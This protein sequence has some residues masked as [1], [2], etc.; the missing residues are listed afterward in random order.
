[1]KQIV[2][3][4]AGKIG[5]TICNIL[6]TCGDYHITVADASQQQLDQADM[7]EST[8]RVQLNVN[9]EKALETNLKGKF[10]VM[11]AAPFHVTSKV[12]EGAKR[13]KI[14]YLDLTEDVA[15][16]QLVENLAVDAEKARVPIG[17]KS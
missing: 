15:M 4:G 16:T 1:M 7:P 6:N 5:V 12:A 3:I 17:K 13:A 2:I 11:S 14:H 9:D 8:A 10:A